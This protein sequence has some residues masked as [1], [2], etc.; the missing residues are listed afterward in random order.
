QTSGTIAYMSPQQMNGDQPQPADDI[1]SLG[2]TLYELL[3]GA[4]PFHSGQIVH[5]VLNKEPVPICERL[6]K[7]ELQNEIP[8]AVESA[9]MACL[10][11]KVEQRLQ[12]AG[13]F[14]E[15]ANSQI[16]MQSSPA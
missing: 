15:R 13:E 9:I 3:T 7:L 5:Q 2:A 14:F 6:A 1:Y 16:S 11:K 4:P 8:A 12:S 10:A